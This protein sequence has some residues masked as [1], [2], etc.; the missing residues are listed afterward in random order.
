[1]SFIG[2]E[3]ELSRLRDLINRPVAGLAVVCGRRRVGKS[4]LIEHACQD[5]KFF[6]FYGL[7]PREKLNNNEQLKHFGELMGAAFSLPPQQFRNWNAAF[8]TLAVFTQEG[9]L[10]FY[11]MRSH[12]WRVRIKIFQRNSKVSGIRNSKKTQT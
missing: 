11:S 5:I 10:S 12:G 2:R 1:M 3:Y 7:G 9:R 6:E 4:T 8:D